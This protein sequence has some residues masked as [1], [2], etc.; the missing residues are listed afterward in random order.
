MGFLL[1]SCR[2]SSYILDINP[3]PDIWFANIFSHYIGC[4]WLCP[5]MHKIFK[6]WYYPI[7]LF[8]L[9]L[10]LLLVSY[11][12]KVLPNPM[13][14]SF[15]SMFSFKSFIVSGLRSLIHF[16]LIFYMVYGKGPNSFFCMWISSF[17]CTICWRE[18]SPPFK[19]S[20]H[21]CAESID[22]RY[23]G[24]FLNSQFYSIG[25]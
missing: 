5:L 8:L 6:F 24:L 11:P 18:Y 22:Q 3:L 23:M 14:C 4:F 19:W 7:H 15:S 12:K 13:S 10:P 20:W 16:E 21:F 17:A 9:L 1:L 2:S 25:L